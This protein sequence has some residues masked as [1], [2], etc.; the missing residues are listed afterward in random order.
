MLKG[1][2]GGGAGTALDE[3]GGPCVEKRRR[4]GGVLDEAK[5]HP[6][7]E[8]AGSRRLN[9]GRYEEPMDA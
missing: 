7:G 3:V 5:R 9:R 6:K 1:H 2:L 4:F 8:S